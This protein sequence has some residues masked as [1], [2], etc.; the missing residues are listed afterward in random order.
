[1]SLSQR[2]LFWWRTKMFTPPQPKYYAYQEELRNNPLI[3]R[4]IN[5]ITLAGN[6]I[7]SG[8]DPH[9]GNLRLTMK[10][11]VHGEARDTAAGA[12]GERGGGGGRKKK[13]KTKRKKKRPWGWMERASE[14]LNDGKEGEWLS[15]PSR[16]GPP[17]PTR[18]SKLFQSTLWATQRGRRSR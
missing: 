12:E 13:K 5:L 9:W 14:C 16:W 1:M 18:T 6:T 3:Q 4:S 17:T 15:G 10:A 11:A 7:D 2:E 8:H